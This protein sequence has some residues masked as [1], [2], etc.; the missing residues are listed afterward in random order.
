MGL[1]TGWAVGTRVRI[2]QAVAAKSARV[3]G[4]LLCA[5]EVASVSEFRCF[6]FEF[7]LSPTY[8]QKSR[9]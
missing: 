6:Y 8:L 9:K 5:G 3:G 7:A 2:K 4:C 1:R